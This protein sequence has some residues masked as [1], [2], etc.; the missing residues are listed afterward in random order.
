[1]D[2]HRV[3]TYNDCFTVLSKTYEFVEIVDFDEFIFP[4]NFDTLNDFFPKN[5]TYSC[6]SE[7][8]N[9]I[10]LINPFAYKSTRPEAHANNYF[11][12][13]MNSLIKINRRDRDVT[14]LSSIQFQNAATMTD[15]AEKELI[16]SLELLVQ[17]LEAS[18]TPSLLF[19]LKIIANKNHIFFI[20]KNDVDYVKYLLKS[21]KSFIYC[22]YTQHK[23]RIKKVEKSLIR[24]FYYLT[25]YYERPKKSV[26]HYKNARSMGIHTIR[27][28]IKD[29]WDFSPNGL[30]GHFTL[31][32]RG[33][34][35][36]VAQN[37]T[38]T[39]RD[40][41]IDFEYIF[42]VLKNYSDFCI[43]TKVCIILITYVK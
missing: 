25:S 37:F 41:N 3:V 26:Y 40:L 11:Y 10:C 15:D 18:K 14:K 8:Q 38:S 30:S 29:S 16:N 21:Y 24:S 6:E 43:K 32:Y 22:V 39:I 34:I 4:R 35:Y 7:S 13:Y 42:F 33:E 17:K 28:N 20:E 9:S 31:H 2:A 27:E 23:D 12:E 19:P 36:K 1:M 5:S